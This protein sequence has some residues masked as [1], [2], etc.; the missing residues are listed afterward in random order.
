MTTNGL[1]LP[2]I[3]PDTLC[4]FNQVNVSFHG[5]DTILQDALKLLM[6]HNV[7]TGVNFLALQEYL[8]RLSAAAWASDAFDAEPLMLTAKGIENTPG[9]EEVMAEVRNLLLQS[10]LDKASTAVSIS[11]CA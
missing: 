2:E 9:P 3:G 6:K 8:P 10:K 5:D 4:P 7:L 1:E 11:A